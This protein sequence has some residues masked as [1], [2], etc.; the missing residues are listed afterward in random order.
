MTRQLNTQNP[1]GGSPRSGCPGRTR[2]GVG[3]RLRYCGRGRASA[4]AEV[5]LAAVAVVA[6]VED[7]VV[8][9]AAD[10]SLGVVGD[11]HPRGGGAVAAY[12]K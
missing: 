11:M 10:G 1:L 5:V 4:D 8:G 3:V 2:T 7:L 12:P 9:Q 6:D